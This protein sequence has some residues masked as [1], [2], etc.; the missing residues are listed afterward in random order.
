MSD[1]A[2]IARPLSCSGE[3]YGWSSDEPLDASGRGDAPP[4][5]AAVRHAEVGQ[6]RIAIAVDE[7][8]LGFDVAVDD[9][10]AVR[11]LQST[12]E[13]GDEVT[14]PVARPTR[15]RT[16]MCAPQR[17][18]PPRRE[19]GEHPDRPRR[20]RVPHRLRCGARV[21]G[22]RW[23]SPRFRTSIGAS[24]V[25]SPTPRLS[26][27]DGRP[28]TP[29]S[30]IIQLG[31]RC[32]AGVRPAS[33]ETTRRFAGLFPLR[34]VRC[35]IVPPTA[36]PSAGIRARWSSVRPSPIPLT[37][38]THRSWTMLRSRTHTR[39]CADSQRLTPPTSSGAS[40]WSSG[41]FARLG[42]QGARG[43]FIAVVGPS[44]SGKSSAVRGRSRAGVGGRRAA[45]V[46]GLVYA[47]R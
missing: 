28:M 46:A 22:R 4:P 30:D 11:T 35:S 24:F 29:T 25:T 41:S 5:S 19:A 3:A 32:F 37:S 10:A 14:R 21:R 45:D 38:L 13:L 8:V 20:Q 44:G 27:W 16:A 2:D 33:M 23:S 47:S 17:R 36:T 12:G 34:Y 6:V 7:D 31:G 15:Q 9:A 40:D 43:R 39:A 42:E 1:A 18:R 26:S